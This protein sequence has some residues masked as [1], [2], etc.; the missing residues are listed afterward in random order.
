MVRVLI[1]IFVLL[2]TT[3]VCS[4]KDFVPRTK[5]SNLSKRVWRTHTTYTIKT[6]N[7]PKLIK[8]IDTTED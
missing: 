5:I 4:G 6:K 3:N 1:I 2:F 7:R 8:H